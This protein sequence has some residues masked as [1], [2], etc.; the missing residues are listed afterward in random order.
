MAADGLLV[1]PLPS[2]RRRRQLILLSG[3]A[4]AADLSASL[5]IT[6]EQGQ[7]VRVFG[8]AVVIGLVFWFAIGTRSALLAF[9]ATWGVLHSYLDSTDLGSSAGGQSLNLSRALGAALVL[10]VG[11]G[12][13]NLPRRR[14][15]LAGPLVAVVIFLVLYAGDAAIAPSRSLGAGDLVRVASGVLVGLAAFYVFDTRER[16]LQ[17]TR[18]V[19]WAGLAVAVMTLFQYAFTRV[20]PGAAHAFFGAGAFRHS[21]NATGHGSV[22]RVAGALG[23]PGETAGFLLVAASFGLLR[24]TL[25]RET[26]RTRGLAAGIG[27]MG[28]AIVSTLTRASTVAFVLLILIW[29]IQRQLRRVSAVGMR[30]KILMTGLILV[31]VAVPV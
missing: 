17:L 16:L 26:G 15:R 5:F 1:R 28:L 21:S 29:V 13:L 4:I 8:A 7:V 27:L 3:A 12:L 2:L 11:L 20:S 30:T 24:F 23:G 9:A 19:F 31:V 18:A 14:V 22:T 25:L 10:G 6:H